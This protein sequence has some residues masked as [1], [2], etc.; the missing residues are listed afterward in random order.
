M[1]VNSEIRSP[2]SERNPT[3]EIRRAEDFADRSADFQSAVS[4]NSSRQ[5]ARIGTS[6]GFVSATP[7]VGNLR[8][9][10]LE[11]CATTFA[12]RVSTAETRWTQRDGAAK[13]RPLV[14]R[15]DAKDAEKKPQ[16]RESATGFWFSASFASLR[17][18][19][20]SSLRPSRLCGFRNSVFGFLSDFGSRISDFPA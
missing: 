8:Y 14:N 4:P 6:A 9:S 15:R 17:F 2:K 19:P 12:Q 7:Q 3:P 20:D 1:K 18:N 16:K 11:V 10:R 5:N 13:A